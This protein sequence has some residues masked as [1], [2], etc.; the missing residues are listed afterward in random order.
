VTS[1]HRW[2]RYEGIMESVR[3]Y[4]NPLYDRVMVEFVSPSGGRKQ[5]EAFW[6]GDRVWRVRFSPN[7]I[8]GWTARAIGDGRDPQ[9][10]GWSDTFECA[11]YAGNNPLY[12]HGPVRVSSDG[13]YLEHSDGTPFFL[14]GDTAW[15]GPM[16][17]TPEEWQ[18]YLQDR[19]AKRFSAVLY[20][21]T[22]FR[23][24]AGTRDGRCAYY[25]RDP[26]RIDPLFF[27]HIDLRVDAINEAGM[28]AVPILLHA[29][30]D[31]FLNV[32][33]DLA[34]REAM[35]LARY[36]VARYGGNKVVWDFVAESTFE[37][38]QIER[39]RTVGR[40]VFGAGSDQPVTLHPYPRRWIPG[41]LIAEPW[42][43]LLGY[44]SDHSDDDGHW[45]W[46]L[47]GPPSTSWTTVPTR[48]VINLEPPYEGYLGHPKL[49][50]FDDFVVRRA[51]YWSILVA[52]PAG[53]V[54][55]AHGVWGWNDGSGPP[56]AHPN[57]G[58]AKPWREALQF[59]GSTSMLHMV[60]LISTIDWWRLRPVSDLLLGQPGDEEVTRTVV[61][62][63]TEARD[64]ALLYT[65]TSAQLSVNLTD[66]DRPVHVTWV[67]ASSGKRHEVG[68]AADDKWTGTPPGH[69]DWLLLLSKPAA[70]VTGQ[71]A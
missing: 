38:E 58:I 12:L 54:Y 17:S 51:S 42:L 2:G 66:F 27:R 44:Q 21:A 13:H 40:Q 56:M 10:D 28:L 34:P 15:N 11:P 8:G 49:T 62:A 4:A 36:I 45:E 50:V 26:L 43:D 70:G 18:F 61:A 41:E 59:P 23:A 5:V 63:R 19:R 39:W 65:P 6:D 14:L 57:T 25:A 47:H 9:L 30:R 31:S 37:G 69:G 64:L 22:Q 52:P 53:V 32:G 29:G 3:D 60:E 7:E 67:E 48:P 68:N 71:E 20:L 1:V 16:L 35:L 46:I 55:G 33:Y 24:S